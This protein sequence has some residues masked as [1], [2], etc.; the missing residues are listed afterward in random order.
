[1]SKKKWIVVFII[2]GLERVVSSFPSENKGFRL[3]RTLDL[4]NAAVSF[5]AEPQRD[6]KLHFRDPTHLLSKDHGAQDAQPSS[7]VPV[8]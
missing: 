7:S 8:S 6:Q 2:E 1:M 3:Y 5:H 4:C